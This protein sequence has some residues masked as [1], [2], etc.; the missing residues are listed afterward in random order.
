MVSVM[1]I[2][3]PYNLFPVEFSSLSLKGNTGGRFGSDKLAITTK[4]STNYWM[5]D[6][7][8]VVAVRDVRVYG[9][10][11]CCFDLLD[12]L[13]VDL[14]DHEMNLLKTQST[15]GHHPLFQ[16]FRF[17]NVDAS[18]VRLRGKEELALAEV[19]VLAGQSSASVYDPVSNLAKGK[20]ATQL[21]TLHDRGADLAV[22]GDL[23]TSTFS[24]KGLGYW[25]VDLG[26]LATITHVHVYNRIDCCK[27]NLNT[28]TLQLFDADY[29]T[30]SVKSFQGSEPEFLDFNM[31]RS[32]GRYVRIVVPDN[33]LMIAEVQVY[34]REVEAH[35]Y[36]R[37]AKDLP[38]NIENF[39]LGKPTE[40]ST[41]VGTG[42]SSYAVDGLTTVYDPMNLTITKDGFK[43]YWMVNLE[44]ISDILDIRVWNR[45]DCCYDSLNEVS[46]E[47]LD[48][49]MKIV[50]T[51]NFV[52]Q[53]PYVVNLYFNNVQGSYIRLNSPDKLYLAEVEVFGTKAANAQEYVPISNLALGKPTDQRNTRNGGVPQLAVDGDI[54]THTYTG[55]GQVHWMVNLQTIASIKSIHI[56]NRQDCCR[57]FLNSFTMYVLDYDHNVVTNQTFTGNE[58][59]FVDFSLDNVEGTFV[60]LEIEKGRLMLGEVQVYGR[61]V[62]TV[63]DREKNL[64]VGKPTESSSVRSAG[65]PEYAVDG[66]TGGY[67]G[68]ADKL[69]LTKENEPGYWMVNLEI[70][71]AIRNVRIYGREDC[72]LEIMNT[73][74]IDI[75][76]AAK[77]VVATQSFNGDRPKVINF[78]F[79]PIVIGQFVRVRT[80]GQLAM[81]EVEV[82]SAGPAPNTGA[83][84]VAL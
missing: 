41:M 53:D 44:T 51:A 68:T 13:E 64:A 23:A 33:F 71:S 22:D 36:G 48:K 60:R 84:V 34:G 45:A 62:A 17:E 67:W 37:L 72:C 8:T 10:E 49:D 56:F 29:N 52:G 61:E 69:V 14:L 63:P 75:L 76:D 50:S 80:P 16:N 35:E 7:Q 9:R 40:Q 58:P 81:S 31:D 73:V 46:A 55:L 70:P 27:E 19:E 12:G 1:Q 83:A 77:Q 43:N 30:V 21:T 11:D 59:D 54:S 78:Y 2:L 5:V 38:A 15:A 28:F 66:N 39:A 6:L 32:T 3:K 42:Y 74:E 20:N 79:E 82:Y 24:T 47:I 57:E 18:Y 26:V 4:H 65:K 25:M